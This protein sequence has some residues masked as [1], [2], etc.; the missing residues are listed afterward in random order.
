MNKILITVIVIFLIG[1]GYYYFQ[2]NQSKTME[3]QN[4]ETIILEEGSGDPA[5]AKDKLTVHYT[6]YLEDGTKFD[7]SYDRNNPFV[8]TLGIGQVI[9]GWDKG[10]EGIKV[11]EKRKIIIPSHLGYGEAGMKNQLGDYI[12]PPNATL[13]FEVEALNIQ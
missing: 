1:G 3:Q 13:I 9:Q 11:G 7:S 10:M 2:N 12:I 8:F 4:L 6:G 5:Q